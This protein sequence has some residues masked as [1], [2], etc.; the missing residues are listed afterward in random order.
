MERVSDADRERVLEELRGHCVAGRLSV[1]EYT[2]RIQEVM[3]ATTLGDLARARR[4]LPI[5]RIPDAFP[6]DRETTG[7]L[8]L[9]LLAVGVVVLGA[10]VA[11]AATV[12]W[13]W[14]L[15]LG[16]GWLLGLAQ[17]RLLEVRRRRHHRA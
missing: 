13:W 9:P 6:G 10:G 5:V 16:A 15:A 2:D 14:L 11:V 7:W 4:D 8:L 17:A 12:R 1:D 3:G